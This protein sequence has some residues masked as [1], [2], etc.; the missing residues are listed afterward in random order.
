MEVIG[1]GFM[2]PGVWGTVVIIMVPVRAHQEP[3]VLLSDLQLK[4]GM[5]F[6]IFLVQVSISQE[7]CLINDL[8]F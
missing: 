7:E 8:S 2:S 5:G 1:S 3:I 4:N 6:H